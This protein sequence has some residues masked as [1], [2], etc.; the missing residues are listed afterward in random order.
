MTARHSLAGT[1]GIPL[2]ADRTY[3]RV[4]S[5]CAED[6]RVR[7]DEVL[8]PDGRRFPAASTTHIR[9]LGR[10]DTGTVV[11]QYEVAF[12]RPGRREVRRTIWWERGRWF[13]SRS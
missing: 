1:N 7:V 8:W 9:T 10:W 13:T 2:E 3:L 6:G 5:E 12:K 11:E 4:V